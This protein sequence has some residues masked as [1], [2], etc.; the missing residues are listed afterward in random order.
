MPSTSD[1]FTPNLR[2]R[3]IAADRKVWTDGMN[4]NMTLIDAVISSFFSSSEMQGIWENSH[5]YTE[6]MTVVD[7][8]TAIVYVC[9]V[10]HLSA[11]LPTTFAEERANNPTYWANYATPATNKG[12]WVGP[13][14]TYAK[15]DFVLAG[16]TKYAFCTTS[17]TSTASFD[18]DVVSGYWI[19]LIDLST[20]GSLVLPV[21]SGAPDASK[22][23]GVNSGGTA[24]I[25]FDGAEAMA[26]LSGTLPV[27]KGGT[28][29]TTNTGTGANVQA[30]APSIFN[31]QLDSPDIL[32][33]MTFLGTLINSLTGTGALVLSLGGT[34]TN[35]VLIAPALGTPA[36]GVLTNCSGL[37]AAALVAG[38]LNNGMTATTQ[39]QASN[40]GKVATDGYVDR[41]AVQQIQVSST[42]GVAT[43]TTQVPYD[44]TI[45]Q[46]TEGD[47]YMS[48]T[49][50]P[51]SA[52]SKLVIEVRAQITVDTSAQGMI[53]GL[54]QDSVADA[55]ICGMQHTN[56]NWMNQV[57]LS[58]VMT[59]GT[60]SATT[61]KFRAGGQ[62]GVGGTVTFNGSGGSRLMGGTMDSFI[63]VMEIGI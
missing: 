26:R 23:T 43:G 47:Q 16:G 13:G 62:A 54:F 17:H 8:D 37:P 22:F 18:N 55:L 45:M 36:S 3:K 31:A 32:N 9:G 19:V 34:L 39:A 27:A 60:T 14:T 6:G 38:A 5:S 59:S 15:N 29:V 35:A 7:P 21:L 4:D 49:I 61:F 52:T 10:S 50:T 30:T 28:G 24:Y 12:A 53:F 51:K 44:D 33:D 40:D 63:R 2:L 25:I 1:T 56:P 42:T 11:G 20:V 46:N 57:T 48:V 58:Y 41:V